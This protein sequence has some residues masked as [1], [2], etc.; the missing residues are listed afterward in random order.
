MKLYTSSFYRLQDFFC[1]WKKYFSN[2]KPHARIHF[3]TESKKASYMPRSIGVFRN[4][5]I[6]TLW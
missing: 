4:K 1:N 3:A 2:F 6:Q 5:K